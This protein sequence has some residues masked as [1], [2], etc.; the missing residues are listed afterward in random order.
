M[1]MGILVYAIFDDIAIN[2]NSK[3]KKYPKHWLV[4]W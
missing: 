2:G 3:E 4:F 1:V